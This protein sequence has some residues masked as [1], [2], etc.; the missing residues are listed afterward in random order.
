VVEFNRQ[1]AIGPPSL[2]LLRA[3]QQAKELDI[4]NSKLNGKYTSDQL[5]TPDS[6][7]LGVLFSLNRSFECIRD[8][9]GDR[10]LNLWWRSRI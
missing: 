5:I 9:Q 10:F 7:S 2:Q 8:F 6:A 1:L 4:P 3:R